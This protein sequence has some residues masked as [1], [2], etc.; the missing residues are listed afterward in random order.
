[1]WNSWKDITLDEILLMLE[2]KEDTAIKEL[3]KS[4]FVYDTIYKCYITR[5]QE[6][7]N[8]YTGESGFCS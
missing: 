8:K 6:L 2:N 5:S 7:L 3:T 4:A 1:V